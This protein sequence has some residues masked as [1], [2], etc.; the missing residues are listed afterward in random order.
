ME[1]GYRDDNGREES[2]GRTLEGQ[3]TVEN[4]RI[5]K[6]LKDATNRVMMIPVPYKYRTTINLYG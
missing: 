1:T 6:A 4:F 5:R 2:T 3:R